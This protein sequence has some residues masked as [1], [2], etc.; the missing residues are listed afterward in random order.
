MGV[1]QLS[2]IQNTKTGHYWDYK[3]NPDDIERVQKCAL[4]II[5]GTEYS[6]YKNA[7][8]IVNMQTLEERRTQLCLNFA[9]KSEANPKFRNWFQ[10]TN[11]TYDTRKKT[12]QDWVALMSQPY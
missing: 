12:K 2:S 11:S 6:S 3:T 4:H 7:L 9:L 1:K 10:H 8:Y 5:L